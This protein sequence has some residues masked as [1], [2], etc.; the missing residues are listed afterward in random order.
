MRLIILSV[1]FMVL[2]AQITPPLFWPNP[3]CPDLEKPLECFAHH[4]TCIH[5][6]SKNIYKIVR[7]RTWWHC[8][9]F[10]I[11]LGSYKE[12]IN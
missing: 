12:P 5:P 4:S 1:T 10:K 8:G 3:G 9:M 7:A 6:E 11:N 2:E